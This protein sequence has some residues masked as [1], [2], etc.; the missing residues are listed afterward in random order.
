MYKDAEKDS[1]ACQ[2]ALSLKEREALIVDH[3]YLVRN[4]AMRISMRVPQ[5]VSLDELISAGSLGLL[6]AV[7]KFSPEKDVQFRTYAQFRIKGAILDELRSMD[8][9]SR[10]LRKKAQDVEKAVA[11]VEREQG[12]PAEEREVAEV[13]DLSLEAYQDVL[14]EIHGAAILNLNASIRGSENGN[15]ASKTFQDQ[16]VGKD[17]PEEKLAEE[18]LKANLAGI[19][20]T[21]SEKE[22]LVLSLYYFEDLTLKEIGEVLE[23]TESRICQIHSAALVKLRVKLRGMEMEIC[24]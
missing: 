9:Y 4:V 1:L 18:E 15:D 12:R 14:T 7:N 3:T 8:W 6:D 2:G 24:C 5:S 22:Q 17:N 10:S 13:M 16:L 21:L 23:R 19:I 11:Y 20:A